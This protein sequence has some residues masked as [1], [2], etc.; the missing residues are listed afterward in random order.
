[1]VCSQSRAPPDVPHAVALLIDHGTGARK[2][3]PAFTGARKTSPF[4]PSMSLS[5]PLLT[6]PAMVLTAREKC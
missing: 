6:K 2:R 3:K 4:L 5:C 1:M